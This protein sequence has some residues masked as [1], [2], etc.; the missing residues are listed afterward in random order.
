MIKFQTPLSDSVAYRYI[1]LS[2]VYFCISQI[3][4]CRYLTNLQIE[5]LNLINLIAPISLVYPEYSSSF[6]EIYREVCIVNSS[7]ILICIQFQ[8]YSALSRS[9]QWRSGFW[10][11]ILTF[12]VSALNFGITYMYYSDSGLYYLG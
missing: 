12:I 6:N 7:V 11:A 5:S 2:Q 1:L 9:Y 3:W 8:L 4:K 10:A